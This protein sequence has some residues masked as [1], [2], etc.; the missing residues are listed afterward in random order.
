ML[1]QELSEEQL[2]SHEVTD[3][4]ETQILNNKFKLSSKLFGFLFITYKMRDYLFP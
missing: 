4:G 1:F 3:Q 2:Q